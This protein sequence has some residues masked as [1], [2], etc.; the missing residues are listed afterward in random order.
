MNKVTGASQAVDEKATK[1][2]KLEVKEVDSSKQ[3][4]ADAIP[5]GAAPGAATMSVTV[6]LNVNVHASQPTLGDGTGVSAQPCWNCDSSGAPICEAG[7]SG[8]EQEQLLAHLRTK[9]CDERNVNAGGPP[10]EGCTRN[11]EP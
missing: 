7:V 9:Y 4:Q 8:P 1:D 6:G 2:S 10:S 5:M 11:V 3:D